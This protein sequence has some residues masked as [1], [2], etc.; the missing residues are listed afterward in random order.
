VKPAPANRT[1]QLQFY[2]DIRIKPL[3]AKIVGY[4]AAVKWPFKPQRVSPNTPTPILGV[5]AAFVPIVVLVFLLAGIYAWQSDGPHVWSNWPGPVA[6]SQS[7]PVIKASPQSPEAING[8]VGIVPESGKEIHGSLSPSQPFKITIYDD[9]YPNE[10]TQLSQEIEQAYT[11]VTQRFGHPASSN[12]DIAIARDYNCNLHGLT[13]SDKRSIQVFTCNTIARQQGIAILAHE[14]VHQLAYDHYGP[15]SPGADRIL[16]EGIA[17]WAAGKYWLGSYSDFRSYVR[18]QRASGVFY[19]LTTDPVVAGNETLDPLYY[20]WA[21]F[22]DYLITT[23]P[24]EKFEQVYVS[25]SRHGAPGSANY[26]AVY[27]RGIDVLEKEWLAWL[28]Q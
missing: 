26:E 19:S 12:F 13:Y 23:Y 10:H 15:T 18:D 3:I 28:D 5:I 9:L 25:E 27:G 7:Q 20:E 2:W 8:N 1:R 11:Y 24:P 22:V 14:I 21:S 16:A 6:Q 4:R 17:T